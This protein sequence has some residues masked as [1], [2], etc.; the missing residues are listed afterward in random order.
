MLLLLESFYLFLACQGTTD[1]KQHLKSPNPLPSNPLHFIAKETIF[2][3]LWDLGFV[4]LF[5]YFNVKHLKCHVFFV[6]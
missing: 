2:V 1:E 4:I 3:L 5:N 6:H